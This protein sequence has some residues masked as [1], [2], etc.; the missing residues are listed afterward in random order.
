MADMN[1]I[2]DKVFHKYMFF[3]LKPAVG[4]VLSLVFGGASIAMIIIAI[5]LSYGAGGHAGTVVGSLAFTA[6][7]VSGFGVYLGFRGLREEERAHLPCKIG[8]IMCGCIC[9]FVIALFVIGV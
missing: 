9:V 6:F 5:C 8:I 4:G 7:I 3:S 2:K 1:K